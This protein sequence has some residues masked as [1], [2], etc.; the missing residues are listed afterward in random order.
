VRELLQR[1]A[2]RRAADGEPVG[3]FLLGERLTLGQPATDDLRPQTVDDLLAETGD[4]IE[5]RAAAHG[6]TP[7][8]TG[9]AGK[10]TTIV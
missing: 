10:P 3:E 6:K 7:F 1:L 8:G 9:G 4:E 2:D 5:G